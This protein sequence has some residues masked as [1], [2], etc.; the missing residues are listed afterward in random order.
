MGLGRVSLLFNMKYFIRNLFITIVLFFMTFMSC[1]VNCAE[2]YRLKPAIFDISGSVIFIPV[3]TAS[4]IPVAPTVVNSEPENVQQ[5]PPAVKENKVVIEV[6]SAMVEAQPTDISFSEGNLKKFCIEQAGDKAKITLTFS[7][8]YSKSKL[9]V[10]CVNNNIVLIINPVQPYG[11]NYYANTYRDQDNP[12]DFRETLVITTKIVEK[13]VVPVNENVKSGSMNEIH[14]AFSNSNYKSDEVYT[15]LTV[16]ELSKNNFLK[17]K[18]YLADAKILDNVFRITGVGTVS[19]QKP[20]ILDNPQRMVF[21]LPN[22]VINSELHGK[23]LTLPNGDVL[24]L[25]QFTPH[26]TR[27]VVYSKNAPQY[28]PVYSPDSQGILLANPRDILTTHLPENKT[29][30]VKF[31]CQKSSSPENF[32]F[33]FDKPLSYAIKRTSDSLYVYFLNAEK[34]NDSAYRS[35]VKNT[36]FSEMSIN[37]LS[38]GMRLRL[39]LT[40]KE[41][42]NTYLSPDGRVFRISCTTKKV[43]KQKTQEEINALGKKEGIITS[44]PKYTKTQNKNVIVIDAGHG[45]KDC[46]ALRGDITEKVI[47]LEV[48]MRLQKIL[49]K[50]GYK[51]YMTRTD[52]TYLSLEDRTNFTEGI[53]PAVFVSVHVNS[54]NSNSPRGIETHYYH[55]ESLELADCV[56]RNLISRVSNTANR[57]LLK[58]RFYVINH[59]TVPAI[60]VEIGFISNDAERAELISPQRQQATAEGIAEGIIEFIRNIK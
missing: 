4:Q 44:A 7:E 34:Y 51:V 20:F 49:Q 5:E 21:D 11:M 59:T 3:K 42:L 9:W 24:K 14:Q 55:D 19:V 39:P 23:E 28:I 52:D 8:K 6:P 38:T 33:E 18:Y 41:N 57:G 56:H 50:K 46:G 31:N 30:I 45:G 13:N 17:T 12:K 2:I 35:A 22:T 36:P 29:N 58:S 43:E 10:N 27:L 1:S 40:D 25:A 54:C 32:L 47:N 26:T 48:C 53:N 16:E 60:L 37:L 15:N